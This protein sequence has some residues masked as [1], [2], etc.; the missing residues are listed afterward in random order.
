MPTRKNE[1]GDVQKKLRPIRK[2]IKKGRKI[3]RLPYKIIL[4]PV[5]TQWNIPHL[6]RGTRGIPGRNMSL[7]YLDDGLLTGEV[8]AITAALALLQQKNNCPR[9][10]AQPGQE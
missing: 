1:I 9:P 10:Q 5:K 6:P 2:M 8:T 3:I 7:F 4:S